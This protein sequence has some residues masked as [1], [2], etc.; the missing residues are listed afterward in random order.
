[1]GQ[2]PPRR[3]PVLKLD[4]LQALPA[5]PEDA[6]TPGSAI[7]SEDD[8]LAPGEAEDGDLRGRVNVTPGDATAGVC[9]VMHS[10]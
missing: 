6:G 3:L 8:P 5:P 9:D 10:A 1:M 2:L 4:G 7:T